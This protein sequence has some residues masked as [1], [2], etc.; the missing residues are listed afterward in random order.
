M[1][2]FHLLSRSRMFVAF[3]FMVCFLDTG[4]SVHLLEL[5]RITRYDV[6]SSVIIVGFKVEV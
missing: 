2:P 4:T 3:A 1:K 5:Q 6:R